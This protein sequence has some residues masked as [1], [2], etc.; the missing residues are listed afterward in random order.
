M[1]RRLE[2]FA[3]G[4]QTLHTSVFPRCVSRKYIIIIIIIIHIL[5]Y[6][7]L[8]AMKICHCLVEAFKIVQQ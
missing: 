4:Q 3:R 5:E 1:R 2:I 6:R 7:R 8:S